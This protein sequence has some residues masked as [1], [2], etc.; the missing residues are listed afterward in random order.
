MDITAYRRRVYDFIEMGSFGGRM[1]AAFEFFMI[2]L[3]VLNVFVVALETV[4]SLWIEYEI[5]FNWFELFSISIVFACVIS[6]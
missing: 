4:D 3:I 1:G 5:F 6:S 2:V